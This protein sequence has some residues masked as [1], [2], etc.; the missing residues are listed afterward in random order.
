MGK[1]DSP[2]LQLR[3]WVHRIEAAAWRT[4]QACRESVD[5]PHIPLPIPVEQW[6]ENPLGFRF[7]VEDLSHL[8]DGAVL[9]GAY[10]KERAIVVSS[11]ITNDSRFRFTCAHELGHQ[12]LH[13][14]GTKAFH[15][16]DLMRADRSR[17]KEWQADRFAAAFL[18][19]YPVVLEQLLVLSEELEMG[20]EGLTTLMLPGV[21]SRSL[22]RDSFLPAFLQRFG[23]SKEAAIYRFSDLVLADGKPFLL[24]EH[25]TDLKTSRILPV[26]RSV[27]QPSL[28]R[29]R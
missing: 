21:R 14:R 18:M 27:V 11:S 2:I 24:P 26:K 22:W 3:P 15:D 10:I 13:R 6:I 16:S 17:L 25:K 1:A 12:I 4:L 5:P 7:G 9:G 28:F 8:G 19:P 20:R 23:V 29:D